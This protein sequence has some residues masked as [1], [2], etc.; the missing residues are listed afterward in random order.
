MRHVRKKET[1]Y[2]SFLLCTD[3]PE[4][5]AYLERWDRTMENV[6]VTDDYETE[7]AKIRQCQEDERFVFTKSGYIVKALIGSIVPHIDR[8]NQAK[9]RKDIDQKNV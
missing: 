4:C 2:V 7:L 5:V 8:L 9:F 6:D 1:T 3:E